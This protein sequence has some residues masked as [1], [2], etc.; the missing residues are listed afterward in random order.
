MVKA[1]VAPLKKK[2]IL[3]LELMGCLTLSRLYTTCK[4]GLEFAENLQEGDLV[5]EMEPT[6]RRTWKF[7]LVLLTYS[8]ADGLV[9]KARK[10]EL[11]NKT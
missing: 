7:G 5:L 8:G 9:R 4:E 6:P 3:R 1:F 2:S 10:E 11:S